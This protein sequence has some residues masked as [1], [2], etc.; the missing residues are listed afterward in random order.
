MAIRGPTGVQQTVNSAPT[1][2]ESGREAADKQAGSLFRHASFTWHLT[3]GQ[4]ECRA[5]A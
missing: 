4:D 1:N 2:G 5:A 3:I